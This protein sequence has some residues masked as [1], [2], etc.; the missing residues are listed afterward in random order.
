MDSLKSLMDKKKFELVL[1]LTES[2][3]DV[4]FLF[5]RI[6]AFL[7]LNKPEE[8]LNVIEKNWNILKAKVDLLAKTHIEILCILNKFDDARLEL[9]RYKELPY[10][11]QQTEELLNEL[12]RYISLEE[13]RFF[14]HKNYDEE[15]IKAMLLSDDIEQCLVGLNIVKASNYMFYIK[16]IKSLLVNHRKQSIRTF[17]LLLL[18]QTNHDENISFLS[19]D[20]LIEVNPKKLE[21]P[22]TGDSFNTIAKKI[23]HRFKNP[24]LSEAALSV[25][26]THLMY[27]YP[28][29]LKYSDEVIIKALFKFSNNLLKQDNQEKNTFMENSSLNESD[30]DQFLEELEE[31]QEMF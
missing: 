24:S 3:N 15:Q 20:G 13:R 18:I 16:E 19:K 21:P 25:L 5:Y 8:A 17:A 14:G 12:I 27:I 4:T 11:N 29:S 31:S 7:S 26:S 10:V 22:F 9:T 23:Y 2:S 1:S 28:K 30:V 6:S